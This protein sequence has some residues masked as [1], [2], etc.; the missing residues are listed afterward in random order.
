MSRSIC[1]IIGVSLIFC[2]AMVFTDFITRKAPLIYRSYLK[3]YYSVIYEEK[4]KTM[5]ELESG[6]V[7]NSFKVDKYKD[8][9]EK[10]RI[11]FILL[12]KIEIVYEVGYIFFALLAFGIHYFFFAYHLIEFIRSQP[13]LTNVLMSVYKSRVQLFFTFVFFMVLIYFYSL[14]FYYFFYYDFPPYTCDS[15]FMCMATV[16]Q[17]TVSYLILS[18]IRWRIICIKY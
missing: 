13:V 14:I 5:N 17:N 12:S 1:S 10:A 4:A 16:F 7:Y 18:I 8:F 9:K 6:R 11:I 3:T 2:S 15:V